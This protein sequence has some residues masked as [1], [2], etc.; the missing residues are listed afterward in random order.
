MRFT[1]LLRTLI[2]LALLS[3]ACGGS[4]TP[5]APSTTTSAR[6]LTGVW[7]GSWQGAPIQGRFVFQTNITLTQNGE[8]LSG[9]YTDQ[10]QTGTLTGSIGTTS[11]RV[12]FTV[13]IPMNL[14]FAGDADA[15][16]NTLTGV[17]S[18]IGFSDRPWTLTRQ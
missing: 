15:A 17:A 10:L 18:G 13:A 4:G 2:G 5:S 16:G 11:S 1:L 8:N 14:M 12:T 6:S 9:S 3:G 7:R